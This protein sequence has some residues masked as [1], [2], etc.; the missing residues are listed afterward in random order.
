MHIEFG[1]IIRFGYRASDAYFYEE[2]HGEKSFT[3]QIY[4]AAT[5]ENTLELRSPT[6]KPLFAM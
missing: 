6:Q 3:T 4:A 2:R 1:L 5:L